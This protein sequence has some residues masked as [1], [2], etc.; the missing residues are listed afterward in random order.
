VTVIQRE[1]DPDFMP[2]VL[3]SPFPSYVS[4]HSSAAGAA[5]EVLASFFPAHA[6]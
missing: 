3:T 1:L 6:E 5:A 4:G 2:H